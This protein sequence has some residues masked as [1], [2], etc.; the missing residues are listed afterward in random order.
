M[1]V[2]ELIEALKDFPSDKFV[3]LYDPDSESLVPVGE[4]S[5]ENLLRVDIHDDTYTYQ[6]YYDEDD[7]DNPIPDEVRKHMAKDGVIVLYPQ[8]QIPDVGD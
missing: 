4:V 2:A 5:D 6:H 3:I 7:P 8:S 1:T